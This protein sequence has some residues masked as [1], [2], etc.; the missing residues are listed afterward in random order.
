[1]RH[2]RS[3][4]KR[5]DYPLVTLALTLD[6]SGFP[7]TA[8]ILPGN[9]SEPKTLRTAIEGLNGSKPT[10]IMDAGITT[11][12]NLAYLKEQ[13][14]NWIGVQRTKTPAV[15]NR[16]PDQIFQT[17]SE[18]QVRAWKLEEE[19]AEQRVYLHSEARQAVSDQIVTTKRVKLEAAIAHLNE[20]IAVPGR[21]KKYEVIQRKVGRLLEK[22]KQ[23]GYHYDIKI[24]KKKGKENLAEKILLTRRTAYDACTEAFGGY[25]LRTSHRAWSCE[26][27]ARTYWQLGEI[28]RSFRTM[29]SDLG[30]RPI[31]HSKDEQIE[32]HLFLSILAF[33][34]VHLIRTKLGKKQI[35]KSWATLKV[36]LNEHMRVT[37]VLPQNKTHCILLEQDRD[38]KPFQRQIFQI[39]G[40]SPGRHTQRRK[41]KRPQKEL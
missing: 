21:P 31:Y 24:V 1:M 3:K 15:P 16:K 5:S 4:E 20:G 10:V 18:M 22:Y 2:G 40:L 25:V 33:H 7:R 23:V 9:A 17:T 14:L 37:T 36:K 26:D 34:V 39:M 27:L 41:T 30:I 6:A 35:H 13:G 29:K 8:E 11:E 28:E 12:A 19:N 32:A 38:L